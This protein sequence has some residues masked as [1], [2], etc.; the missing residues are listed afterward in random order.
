MSGLG[1]KRDRDKGRKWE[2]GS[3]KR[4]RKAER[5]LSNQVLS[6]GM[7]KFLSQTESGSTKSNESVASTSQQHVS[8]SENS[9]ITPDAPTI[10]I[11]RRKSKTEMACQSKSDAEIS[12]S[13]LSISHN[14][15]EEIE[16]SSPPVN[17]DASD[18][19]KQAFASFDPGLWTFPMTDAQ[20]HD[21][22]QSG[23]TQPLN[24]SNEYYPQDDDHR[25]FSN[26]HF[27]RKLNNGETQR[28]RWLVYSSSKNKVFCFPCR[29]FSN[30]QTQM[31]QDGCCDWKHLSNILHRHENTKE[32]MAYMFQWITLEKGIKHG[33]TIDQENER[34]ILE[35]QKHWY[36]LFERLIDIINFL[37][38]HNM[39]FRG[40]RESLKTD[41]NTKN[42]GNFIDLFKLMSKYDPTLQKHINR[43]NSKQLAHHYLSHDIQ[44]EL[45]TLMS[46]TVISEV[47]GRIKEAKYYS[48]LLDCTRDC[49]R[50]EQMSVT[51]RYCN[52]STGTIEE[53]FIGFLAVTET[54][55]EYMTNAILGELEKNDLDIQD[56][57]GQGYDNGAN[58]VGIN[59]G[60]KTRILN[61]NPRAFFTPCGCH[62]WNLLLVDAANSSVAAKTFFGFIQKFFLL[63]SSSSKRWKIIKDKLKVTIKPLSDTRWESRIQAVKAVLLQFDDVVEC[64]ENLKQQTEQS[65]TLSDC[66][67]VLNEMFSL[68]FIISLHIWY[69]LLTRVNT[70]SKLWQSVQVH[71][72]ITLEHLQ[73]FCDWIKEYRQTGFEKCLSDA[74]QFIEKSS[75]DFPK[76]FKNKRVAKK[77][78]V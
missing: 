49:S 31:V 72:G 77:K 5:A 74:R 42:S 37:A 44:N 20:R 67:S 26:F 27:S 43:I 7:M 59:S 52:T 10:D 76:D 62:S 55:G 38:S 23:P 70:I 64:I 15:E 65:D 58:M 54:T 11:E 46:N 36:N 51:I 45:I 18:V 33:K 34:L 4:K 16:I 57:R 39:A 40:H 13:T 41:E 71:L 56:C 75:Y 1:T 48:F 19:V 3:A 68:E 60:V 12:V 66:D 22:V 61:I 69:E 25:H 2:S 73:K 21:I 78:D 6:S 35:S 9:E 32:H 8:V 24:N 29:L 63:F 53:N 50:V 47:I 30:S 28:R 14:Q 17:R